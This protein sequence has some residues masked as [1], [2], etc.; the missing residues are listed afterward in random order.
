M[1][2]QRGIR[3]AVVAA[4]LAA[5]GMSG[6]ALAVEECPTETPQKEC[7]YNGVF[8]SPQKLTIGSDGSV[9]VNA[10]MG[11]LLGTAAAKTAIADVDFFSFDAKAGDKVTI[12][13]DFGDK[14]GL[15]GTPG[16]V[17]TLL[18]IFG[19]CGS[20][21]FRTRHDSD[22]GLPVDPGSISRLDA[23]LDLVF[24]PMTGTYTVGVSS[25]ARGFR[26]DGAVTSTTLGLLANGSYT[27][28]ISGV[29]APMQLI[30]I[31][32]KPGSGELAPVNTKSRG[33]VPVALIS[34]ADFDAPRDVDV[35]SKSLTF[36]AR[37]NEMSLSRCSKEGTDV[38]GDGRL[39][40]V[41]HFD[42]QTANFEPGD[43][44]GILKGK[45]KAGTAFEGRGF[46]KVVPHEKD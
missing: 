32:I 20:S 10:I 23:R 26:A 45:T 24:L 6:A 33:N 3:Y 37:G 43:L 8:L 46:L 11:T 36:G 7:E 44:E 40:L 1:K 13:I 17:D 14:P 15:N 31:E 18:A 28:I 41:C 39:D 5:S 42:N 2:K 27:L 4:F 38:N 22:P 16:R 12:D 29:T 19:P 30:N 9:T 34:Y 25:G 21:C 35:D